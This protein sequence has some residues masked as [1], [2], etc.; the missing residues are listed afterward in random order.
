MGPS[1]GRLV[2]EA[3][4]RVAPHIGCWSDVLN[5]GRT[6]PYVIY[7]AITIANK[8]RQDRFS[9]VIAVVPL[10][11]WRS[12]RH[13]T[14]GSRVSGCPLL[15]GLADSASLTPAFVIALLRSDF[16]ANLSRHVAERAGVVRDRLCWNPHGDL[17]R[18]TPAGR[19]FLA[20]M[21][22]CQR[23][24]SA[25]QSFEAICSGRAF[26]QRFSGTTG[27]LPP[28]ARE[29][30]EAVVAS[31]LVEHT[32]RGLLLLLQL[33]QALDPDNSHERRTRCK[34]VLWGISTSWKF[35]PP[36]YGP[37]TEDPN[38][39]IHLQW[40]PQPWH[41]ELHGP[42]CQHLTLALGLH[43]LRSAGGLEEVYGLP[44]A[45]EKALGEIASPGDGHKEM[46]YALPDILQH[47]LGL[48]AW[49]LET[50]CRRRGGPAA[51]GSG[52]AA[53]GS[54]GAMDGTSLLHGFI[55][56]CHCC[57][58]CCCCC[59]HCIL[60]CRPWG[61]SDC[62]LAHI[63]RGHGRQWQCCCPN[64]SGVS[65]S[66]SSRSGPSLAVA[67]RPPPAA[68]VGHRG[69]GGADGGGGCQGGRR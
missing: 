21:L 51:G 32:C 24:A 13:T 65:G 1:L 12:L 56:F 60:L 53:S 30:R 48:L 64:N 28:Y 57:C 17:E 23:A 22:A 3:G 35:A 44:E 43:V 26:G 41:P 20:C 45:L 67:P 68:R 25:L 39:L 27:S 4:G 31:N 55:S 69:A 11:E 63:C 16:L 42:S 52:T 36:L 37:R 18:G 50:G 10:I 62:D 58:C 33:P 8:R 49:H 5:K 2:V 40:F 54:V 66:N 38:Y 19:I 47:L 29:A 6:L 59:C 15:G 34:M 14:S 46:P 61:L 9:R 7:C